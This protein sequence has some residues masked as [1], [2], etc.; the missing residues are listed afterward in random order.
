MASETGYNIDVEGFGQ[1]NIPPDLR[2]KDLPSERLLGKGLASIGYET[3][4]KG[5]QYARKDFVGV[6]RDIFRNEADVL[7]RLTDHENVV[8]THGLTVDRLSCSLVLEYMDDKLSTLLQ[9]R[10]DQRRR[11]ATGTNCG[12]QSEPFELQEALHL[13]LQIAKGMEHLHDQGILHGDLKIRNIL[14]THKDNGDKNLSVES[15]KVADFGLIQTKANSMCYASRQARKL[16]MVRWKAPENL[17]LLLSEA[18][19]SESDSNS[20]EE[21]A[22][23]SGVTRSGDVYSFAMICFQILTGEEP[24]LKRNWKELVPSIVSGELR[25]KLP[26][27][28]PPM[29]RDL[30]EIC[31]ATDP[32]QRRPFSYIREKLEHM[33]TL[34]KWIVK[35][36]GEQKREQLEKADNSLKLVAPMEPNFPISEPFEPNS[37]NIAH[38][39]PDP[40]VLRKGKALES[41][42]IQ[43]IFESTLRALTRIEE[44]EISKEIQTDSRPDDAGPSANFRYTTS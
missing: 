44:L 42:Y 28:C 20:D 10:K 38:L 25:P 27:S 24:Y 5:M 19:S 13:M 36:E 33:Y 22:G 21:Y 11:I 40:D 15:V 35:E 31:W 9:K 14:V 43:P 4:W 2:S 29:L 12:N 1:E 18:L 7:V 30:L 6:P 39:V 3:K 32:Y 17:K 26:P 41:G 37:S 16:D 8:K 34:R 23:S